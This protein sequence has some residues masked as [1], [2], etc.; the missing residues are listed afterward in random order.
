MSIAARTLTVS[1]AVTLSLSMTLTLTLTMSKRASP[2]CVALSDTG[3]EAEIQRPVRADGVDEGGA[4]KDRRQTGAVLCR[5]TG[6]DAYRRNSIFLPRPGVRCI[7]HRALD[8]QRQLHPGFVDG[9]VPVCAGRARDSDGGHRVENL[10]LI[11]G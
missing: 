4:V 6:A 10:R 8:N 7:R 2:S 3:P 1:R 11:Q 5:V 9:S